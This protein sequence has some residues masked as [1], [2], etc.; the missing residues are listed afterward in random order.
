[1]QVV[2]RQVILTRE[3]KGGGGGGGRA[4]ATPLV[5]CLCATTHAQTHYIPSI[6]KW[7][8]TPRQIIPQWAICRW[9]LN[10]TPTRITHALTFQS[11]GNAPQIRLYESVNAK[12]AGFFHLNVNF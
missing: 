5:V 3:G 2:R 7:F 1:M 11:S 10:N 12:V 8:T 4:F 6:S 9:T